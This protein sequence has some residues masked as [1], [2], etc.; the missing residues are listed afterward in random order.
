LGLAAFVLIADIA[1]RRLVINRSDLQQVREALG[2]TF[3][4]GRQA[5]EYEATETAGRMSGLKRAKQRA[6]GSEEAEPAP[7]STAASTPA[8]QN[9]STQAGPKSATPRSKPQPPPQPEG[10]LASRLLKN[11]QKED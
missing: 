4:F 6:M 7:P 5:A 10:T 8:Q 3:G 11:R 9:S 2:Q 1:V